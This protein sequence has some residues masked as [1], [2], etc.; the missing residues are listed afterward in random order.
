MLFV[1]FR[2]VFYICFQRHLPTEQT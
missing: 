2:S 1:T